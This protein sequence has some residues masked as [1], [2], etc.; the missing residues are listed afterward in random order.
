MRSV[1]KLS[2]CLQTGILCLMFGMNSTLPA[3]AIAPDKVA[4]TAVPMSEAE[5]LRLGTEA[6]IFGYPLVTMEMTR[7][8][9]TN[10]AK[11]EGKFAPMGQLSNLRTYPLPS[12]KAVTAPN[13]DTLYSFTWLDL[14]KEP[15]IF[16]IPNAEGRYYLMPMLDGWT[17]VFQVPGTRTTGAKAQKYAIV[18]PS[19]SGKLP[20]GIKEYKSPTNMVWILGRTYCTGTPEDYAKAHSF[21]DKL[22]LTPLSAYGSAYTPTPG[23]VDDNVDMKTPVRN[24]VGLLGAESYF[25]LLAKL[26][27]S[28]PPVAADAPMVADMAKIGIV[29]GQDFDMSKLSPAVSNSLLRVPKAAQ[30]KIFAHMKEAGTIE[31]GWTS[32]LHTGIYGIDYLQ[33]ALITAFGLG[34]NRPQDAVYPTSEVDSDGKTYDGANKYIM[35]FAKG[36]MPPVNAFWSLTMYDGEFFFVPNSLN[37]YTV[38]F[39]SQFKKNKDGSIDLL[40]QKDA[41]SKEMETNWLPAPGGK[42]I[43]MLRMYWPKAIVADG[44]YKIPPVRK[45]Q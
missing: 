31:N 41:P 12:D 32:T 34:A 6:Y 29:P 22:F 40:I 21:Q 2:V 37:R 9:L 19:F 4:V 10:V 1:R 45:V 5:A 15:Y 43:L 33:R 24:Q 11:P 16:G 39:R 20:K 7:R 28:N 8:V 44:K 27:K 38:G 17:D 13:A 3:A 35:H 23:V 42:F 26:M 18:G 36:Q 30:E 14:G 25:K